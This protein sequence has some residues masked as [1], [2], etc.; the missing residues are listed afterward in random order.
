M[1]DDTGN[2][3]II[4]FDA[5][6]PIGQEISRKGGTFEWTSEPPPSITIPENDLFGLALIKKFI[7]GSPTCP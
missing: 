5:C 1:L 2:A 4:D 6:L 7:V 3:M